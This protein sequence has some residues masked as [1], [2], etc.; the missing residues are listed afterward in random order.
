MQMYIKLVQTTNF[1]RCRRR[2]CALRWALR[3]RRAASALAVS[4]PTS[5]GE[6]ERHI[7][8]WDARKAFF[9]ADL[10]EKVYDH[11][12]RELWQP[13]RCGLLLKAMGGGEALV[14]Q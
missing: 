13:R 10:K 1:R 9:N 7:Q 5:S 11:P 6:R 14:L 12:G 3:R 4:S 2:A 8:V